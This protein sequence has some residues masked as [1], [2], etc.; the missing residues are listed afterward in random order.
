MGLEVKSESNKHLFGSTVKY[1]LSIIDSTTGS[2]VTAQSP[3]VAIRRESD[4][5]F[6]DGSVFVDTLGTPT[7]LAMS[8]VGATS[9]PGL[10]VYTMLDPGPVIPAPPTLQLSKDLYELR[11]VNAGAPPSGGTMHSV[12]EF[13]KQLRDINTQGS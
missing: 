5:F 6:F 12:R 3:T 1:Y 2:P 9:N 7:N 13:S 4:G 11:F 8:E 10:Y